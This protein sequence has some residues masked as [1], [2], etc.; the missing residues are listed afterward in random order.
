MTKKALIK[1][2]PYFNFLKQMPVWKSDW[3]GRSSLAPNARQFSRDV[4]RGGKINLCVILIFCF[5]LSQAFNFRE[6][7]YM[8]L[9]A[10][11]IGN[12]VN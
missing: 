3:A 4:C 11:F 10:L 9:L 7:G 5:A 6:Q 12:Q 2:L 1:R 8:C